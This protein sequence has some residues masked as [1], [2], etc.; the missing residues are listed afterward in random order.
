MNSHSNDKN[1][2]STN[3]S[4]SSSA[5]LPLRPIALRLEQRM[6][7]GYSIEDVLTSITTPETLFAEARAELSA[8]L[9]AP[10]AAN[11]NS[12]IELEESKESNDTVSPVKK[13][14]LNLLLFIPIETQEKFKKDAILATLM[15]RTIVTRKGS[16]ITL[17]EY[18]Q[19]I[20]TENKIYFEKQL[21]KIIFDDAV[22]FYLLENKFNIK[23]KELA[24]KY[25]VAIPNASSS[26]TIRIK[27]E[28]FI[29][30]IT[31]RAII[32][33]RKNKIPFPMQELSLEDA[34][35]SFKE[36]VEFTP[37]SKKEDIGKLKIGMAA[38]NYFLYEE[39][40]RVPR[41]N[42]VVGP[43]HE[44]DVDNLL[45]TYIR[46]YIKECLM[47]TKVSMI[48]N[49]S[50][51]AA[52]SRNSVVSQ[53]KPGVVR[54]V[55]AIL[56]ANDASFNVASAYDSCGGW[57]DR[58]A[59]FLAEGAKHIVY[60]DVNERLK[61]GY[62]QLFN[63]YK[64]DGQTITF[65]FKPAEDLT[66][67]QICPAGKLHDLMFSGLPFFSVEK[68]PGANQAHVRYPAVET[69]KTQFLYKLV[70]TAGQSLHPDKGY[71]V[72]NLADFLLRGKKMDFVDP[73]ITFVKNEV[74]YLT[75]LDLD[76]QY[77]VS[78]NSEANGKYFKSPLVVFKRNSNSSTSIPVT[79]SAA[80]S[81]KKD[82][83]SGHKRKNFFDDANEANKENRPKPQQPVA[84]QLATQSLK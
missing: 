26:A 34:K 50:L 77:P 62:E 2:S 10:A 16:D 33:I 81:S 19:F 45:F 49:A 12:Q 32:E 60:N 9:P 66:L 8:P 40:L 31:T 80:A 67:D 20:T 18:Q 21:H 75:V 82:K 4:H 17:E 72:L 22:T 59:G 27:F 68:Y 35:K 47:K 52:L 6:Q 46:Q 48:S 78:A 44:W 53:F 15:N 3:A 25:N 55:V 14:D 79:L 56:K 51:H 71:M 41:N 29:R 39:R 63:N 1:L 30:A 64:R 36:L 65:L 43:Y 7:M 23:L 73:L 11:Q 13:E 28:L 83:V 37:A 38:S 24:E 5:G 61:N 74:P 42:K 69:W 76:L 84:S 70:R 57:G 54:D 58:L